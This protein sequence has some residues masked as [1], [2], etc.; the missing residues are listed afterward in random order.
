[1]N[2][3]LVAYVVIFLLGLTIAGTGTQAYRRTGEWVL[4]LVALGIASIS[5]YG[6]VEY[7]VVFVFNQPDQWADLLE[8]VL[9]GFGM[10]C[11]FYALFGPLDVA[12]WRR[13]R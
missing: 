12:G 1:M 11:L 6:V 2:W 7:A 5:S 10:C 13:G 4:L 3:Y 8:I 9:I